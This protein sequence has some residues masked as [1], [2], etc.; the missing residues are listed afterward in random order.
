MG[1]SDKQQKHE[2]LYW[3]FYEQGSKQAVRFG[4]WKAVRMPIFDGD[5]ELYDLDRD[6]GEANNVAAQH[7]DLVNQARQMMMAAHT[8]NPNWQ[9]RGN[10][11]QREPEPG[12]GVPRF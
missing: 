9:A 4:K 2:Y 1:E 5:I 3:E 12:D 11:K 10:R 6:L 8:P 7:K